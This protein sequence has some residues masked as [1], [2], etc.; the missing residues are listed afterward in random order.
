MEYLMWTVELTHL[1]IVAR[2]VPEDSDESVVQDSFC[3]LIG[4]VR[5]S[6]GGKCDQSWLRI[7][8]K[9]HLDAKYK[10]NTIQ[11]ELNAE[12]NVF[13]YTFFTKLTVTEILPILCFK[14]WVKQDREGLVTSLN[15]KAA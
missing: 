11:V 6:M 2:V 10:I 4:N 7:T 14:E 3:T 13:L 5:F 9:I 1:I 15:A 12:K 8:F